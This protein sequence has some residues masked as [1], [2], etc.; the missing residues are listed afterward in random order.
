MPARVTTH[1]KKRKSF[2]NFSSSPRQESSYDFVARAMGLQL[3]VSYNYD[4]Q[5]CPV[6]VIVVSLGIRAVPVCMSGT[7]NSFVL[8]VV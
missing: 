2:G 1:F 5:V 6:V 7:L 4:S 3:E 8:W